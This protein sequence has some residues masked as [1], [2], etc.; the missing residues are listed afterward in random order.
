MMRLSLLT[1]LPGLLL[2][3]CGP[4]AAGEQGAGGET[5]SALP[6]APPVNALVTAAQAVVNARLKGQACTSLQ[7]IR[8]VD[9]I[10]GQ[11]PQFAKLAVLEAQ[12]ALN[13]ERH[14][15][16]G[17]AVTDARTAP[18][19]G[20]RWTESEGQPR[21]YCFGR[22]VVT[23]AQAAT[24]ASLN[25]PQGQRVVRMTFEL[26]DAP[27]W[28]KTPGAA[29]LA[30]PSFSGDPAVLPALDGLDQPVPPSYTAP[31]EGYVAVPAS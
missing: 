29:A 31:N 15:V 13:V 25:A 3:S 4:R 12:G 18:G 9:A 10:E 7:K 8:F 20:G 14:E 16:D 21:L 2:L 5:A 6:P 1:L 19:G 26:R 30:R 27:A 23:A 28:L 24:D 17:S 11:T 22:W